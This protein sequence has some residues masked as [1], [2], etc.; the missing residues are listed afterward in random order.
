M[1]TKRSVW[2]GNCN[3]N[4]ALRIGAGEKKIKRP[5]H[6]R[7]VIGLSKKNEA[8][9]KEIWARLGLGSANQGWA[10]GAWTKI[11]S[12]FIFLVVVNGSYICIIS[13]LFFGQIHSIYSLK[14]KKIYKLEINKL[15]SNFKHLI[16]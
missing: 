15:I 14:I 6:I 8:G 10:F 3:C 4:G 13:N 7:W 11:C 9:E 5:K 12:D 16:S 1:A 2:W